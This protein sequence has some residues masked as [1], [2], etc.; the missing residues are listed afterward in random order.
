MTS[1][2][3]VRPLILEQKEPEAAK[4][5]RYPA[6]GTVDKR[7]HLIFQAAAPKNLSTAAFVIERE[8][9]PVQDTS[10]MEPHPLRLQSAPDCTKSYLKILGVPFSS[11]FFNKAAGSSNL[12]S[13]IIAAIT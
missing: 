3:A 8:C 4:L 9:V 11:S 7:R 10:V 12:D 13:R 5:Q 2:N 1:S 6:K